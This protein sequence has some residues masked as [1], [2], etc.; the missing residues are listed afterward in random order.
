MDMQ[1]SLGICRGGALSA[2]EAQATGATGATG[3]VP[4]HTDGS[5]DSTAL[6]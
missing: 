2:T 4:F 6:T 5:L 1:R 3:A